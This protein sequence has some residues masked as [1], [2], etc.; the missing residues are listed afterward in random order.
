MI[1]KTQLVME[2]QLVVEWPLVMEWPSWPCH[3]IFSLLFTVIHPLSS[4]APSLSLFSLSAVSSP[5]S[6]IVWPLQAFGMDLST[7][8]VG[9]GVMAGEK[10]GELMDL[11]DTVGDNKRENVCSLV[12]HLKGVGALWEGIAFAKVGLANMIQ[13]ACSS[14]LYH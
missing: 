6:G 13:I 12:G 1:P 4:W 9:A 14:F 8:A 10:E 11:R 7:I 3:D 2:S 5:N